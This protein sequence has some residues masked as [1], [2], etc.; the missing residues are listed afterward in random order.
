[1]TG[2]PPRDLPAPQH[3]GGLVRRTEITADMQRR[4]GNTYEEQTRR[5]E[6]P[7]IDV[8]ITDEGSARTHR[9][10]GSQ[11]TSGQVPAIDWAT[12]LR[13]D[14]AYSANSYLNSVRS[15]DMRHMRR[16]ADLESRLDDLQGK[17]KAYASM[18]VLSTLIPLRNG[19]TMT[20]VAES[21]GMG[22]TMWM[23][24]PNFRKQ[25]KS[26]ARDARMA[27]EDMSE[28]RRRSKLA[29]QHEKIDKYREKHNGNLSPSMARRLARIELEER[30][31]R[32]P[33][34]ETSAALTHL[35]LSEAAFMQ[36]REAGAD[37][38]A[39]QDNYDR[40]MGRLWED[41][42]RD[43][44]DPKKVQT[45]SRIIMG[46]RMKVEPQL[47][48]A[49]VETAH[50][51]IDMNMT[52]KFDPTTGM[53]DRSW[54]GTWSS[55]MGEPVTGGSFTVRPPYTE[56]QH[57]MALSS[58]MARE[59]E[60]AVRNDNLV[61]LNQSLLAYGSA[62]M[63][64][65]QHLDVNA[66]SGPMGEKVRRARR[67]LDAMD[68]DGFSR[69]EQQDIYADSFVHAMDMIA[70]AH[71]DIER[72]WAQQYGSQW[73]AEMRDFA[74]DPEET[75][76][77]WQRGEFYSDSRETPGHDN[78]HVDPHA[79]RMREDKSRRRWQAYNRSRD[80]QEYNAHDTSEFSADKDFE[81]NDVDDG[82]DMGGYDSNGYDSDGPELSL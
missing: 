78:P 79:D 82:F 58:C 28:A 50:G 47:A 63:I 62:G 77:R 42:E 74:T 27:L 24:S 13:R 25:T 11:Q 65:D 55:R 4:D 36:M 38:K 20:S 68:V 2:R 80:N 5:H 6:A 29:D 64:R 70:K 45:V 48:N 12:Q 18:M 41:V 39:I 71:P 66:V 61:D 14:M 1:M 53:Y 34:N 17:H 72:H 8:E 69:R 52:E 76:S 19:I 40:L 51:E 9:E 75:Y 16:Q 73:R 32:I 7:T 49:F 31:G 44:L 60:Q 23:L 22:V 43:G 30:D 81:L 35:G 37:P 3:D 21:V 59:M 26:F 56:M 46:Q 15:T 67:S 33:F 10:R 54:D 57:E